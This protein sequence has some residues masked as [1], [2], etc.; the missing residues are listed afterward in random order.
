MLDGI[1]GWMSDHD[2]ESV[3]Q[4]RGSMN[5]SAIGD[6]GAYERDVY[7]KTITTTPVIL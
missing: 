5:L 4:L 3:V 2:Y 1:R 7:I 6:P